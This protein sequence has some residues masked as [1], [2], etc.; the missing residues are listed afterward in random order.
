MNIEVYTYTL[1][2]KDTYEDAYN[3]FLDDFEKRQF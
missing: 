1:R 2:N 3:T